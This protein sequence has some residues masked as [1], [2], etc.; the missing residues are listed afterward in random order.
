MHAVAEEQLIGDFMPIMPGGV[1]EWDELYGFAADIVRDV[2]PG[3]LP[4]LHHTHAVID[5]V[6]TLNNEQLERARY[7]ASIDSSCEI[8]GTW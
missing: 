5:S 7:L 2:E 4:E 3:D 6:S 8:E 1:P